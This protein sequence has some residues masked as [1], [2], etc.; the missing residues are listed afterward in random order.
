M[1]AW[2]SQKSKRK[3]KERSIK[4]QLLVSIFLIILPPS[5]FSKPL[6]AC[7]ME[8]QREP[9]T[10]KEIYV[11]CMT[12]VPAETFRRKASWALFMPSALLTTSYIIWFLGKTTTSENMYNSMHRKGVHGLEE[13]RIKSPLRRPPFLLHIPLWPH[14]SKILERDGDG[15]KVGSGV[16]K[17]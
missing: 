11:Q 3:L 5:S 13:R 1:T 15:V 16:T 10:R 6:K 12:Q 7:L 8:Y 17:W 9:R 4:S 2:L 14:I